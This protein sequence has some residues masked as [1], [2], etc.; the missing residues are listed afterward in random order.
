MKVKSIL[1]Y[2]TIFLLFA[3]NLFK[4]I[5]VFNYKYASSKT[6]NRMNCIIIQK[7]KH[8]RDKI[9]YLVKYNSN[10][11]ILNIYEN[12]YAKEDEKID[13]NNYANY[14]YGDILT[15]RGNISIP[16]KL[17]NPY[18]F[19]YKKYLNS[20]NIVATISTYK[21]EKITNK[22]SNIIMKLGYFIKSEIDK[23]IDSKMSETE[24][25]LFKS[26][27]Y[28]NDIFLSESIENSFKESGISHMLA[29]SGLHLMY[30]LK[31]LNYIL[32]DM[33]KKIVILS[34]AI[35]ISIF[36]I[37]SSMSISVIRASIMSS[38]TI[39]SK[40]TN[41]KTHICSYKKLFIAFILLFLYNPYS[42]F[43]VSFQ[44][45]FLATL[46]IISYNNLIFSFFMVVLKVSKK[47]SYI[48]EILAMS[49]SANMLLI[50][51]QIYYFGKF[52]LISFI[53][54][55]LLSPI[56]SF[57]L[58]IGFTSLF[59]IFIPFISDIFLT[60]NIVILKIIILLTNFI[61]KINYFTIFIPKFNYLELLLLYSTIFFQTTKK[62]IP[63][64][65][66]KNH[67]KIARKVIAIVTI[68]TFLY[69]ISMYIYR[70]Y[71]EEYT[72][73]FNVEQGNMAII[74][75]K[76][77]II[78]IDIGSTNKKLASNTLKTFLNAKA[79][80]TIDIIA[81][82]HMHEDH[83]NGI[84]EISE[85]FNIN[86]VI[87]S[88]PITTQKGEYEQFCKTLQEKNI[89][90][91]EVKKDDCLSLGNI[92]INVLMPLFNKIIISKDMLN[93]NS[94][95]YLL[96]NN[97]KNYLFM[98]DSTI[99]T[100]KELLNNTNSNIKDLFKN[101]DVIQIGHHGS[102]TSTSDNFI[103]IIKPCLAIISSKK[104]KYGHPNKE[105][106]DILN[107]YN[108]DVKITENLGAIKIK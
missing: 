87:Y 8:E 34:N 55:V 103:K 13:L 22:N 96:Q 18:E 39:I 58:F 17:N 101:L 33:N 81:I 10:N 104:E 27:I 1:F 70:T 80:N 91:I 40:N 38:I 77:K 59:L 90:K 9:S 94:V 6:Q 23:I 24:A 76:R 97:N 82:T 60:S 86:S 12:I 53:S 89:S 83:V 37:I 64:L 49:L 75:S 71:F 93:S 79:I 65:F 50:P 68:F 95:I 7:T 84:Y 26:M 36:C 42:I 3:L 47:F 57:E 102:K 72:Y 25:S 5:Y 69:S 54:N 29:V 14:S 105:T 74:R 73:F 4:S 106:L 99:E 30:I 108:F 52:E 67:K 43:N 11:F 98:G 85:N 56:I 61:Q 20:N 100:E 28:G 88:V 51:L 92:K 32:K 45:S 2:L 35:F 16:K 62:F 41:S 63:V 78:V 107:K 21:V 15:F 66:T 44:M 46:G 19:D 48:T 31:I